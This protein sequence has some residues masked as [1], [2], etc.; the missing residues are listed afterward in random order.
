MK[1][2]NVLLEKSKAFALRII[3]L[4]QYLSETKAFVLSKQLLRSGTSI[5]ANVREAV[6]GQTK[7][8]FYAKLYIAY[9]EAG[10]TQYWL[11]LLHESGHL[12]DE[13]FNSVYADCNEVTRLLAA[14]TKTQKTQPTA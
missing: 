9:K 7:A 6:N 4:Y 3:K 8:D 14:I 10:E 11:E 12:S 2:N 13:G 1:R 5:G